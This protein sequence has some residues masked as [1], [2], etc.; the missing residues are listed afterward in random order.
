[1]KISLEPEL[2]SHPSCLFRCLGARILSHAS[3]ERQ[4]NEGIARRLPADWLTETAKAS[5]P[6]YLGRADPVR[7]VKLKINQNDSS[8]GSNL[9]CI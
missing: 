3:Q 4:K 6:L 5:K 1:M 7:R 8:A 9:A 2:S